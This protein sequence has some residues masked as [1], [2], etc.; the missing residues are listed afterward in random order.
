MQAEP[1]KVFPSHFLGMIL[2][3]SLTD[4]DGN[5]IFRETKYPEDLDVILSGL[6]QLWKIQNGQMII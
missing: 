5:E 1:R 3:V 2:E 6:S 4:A